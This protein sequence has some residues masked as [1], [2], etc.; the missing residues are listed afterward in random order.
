MATQQLKQRERMNVESW[1]KVECT[2]DQEWARTERKHWKKAFGSSVFDKD[3]PHNEGRVD[4]SLSMQPD[5]N[6]LKKKRHYSQKCKRNSIETVAIT[7]K[8]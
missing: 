3:I 5:K 6:K 8:M 2:A 7:F 4:W 1:C